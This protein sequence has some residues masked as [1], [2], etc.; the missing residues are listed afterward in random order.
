MINSILLGANLPG[1]GDMKTSDD[2]QTEKTNN[3]MPTIPKGS[4]QKMREHTAVEKTW[5][6][7][8]K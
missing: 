8:V 7:K 2:V 5:M 1:F 6:K 3:L 4:G